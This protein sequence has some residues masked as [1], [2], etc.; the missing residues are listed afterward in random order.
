MTTVTTI[1][2]VIERLDALVRRSERDGSRLGYFAALY[3]AVT[4]EVRTAIGEGRFEDGDRMSRFDAAFGARYFTAVDALDRGDRPS[5]CWAVAFA[6]VADP[7]LIIAQ[8]LLLGVNAHINLDLA[9]AAAEVAPGGDIVDLHRDFFT[10]N[11]I[12]IHV[13]DRI[14]GAL[15]DVSPAMKLLDFAGWWADEALLSFSV[16]K[17][18]SEA[19]SEALRL[20]PQSATER[21]VSMAT[22][23][24]KA[25]HLALRLTRPGPPASWLVPQV[26]E[27]EETDIAA[28]IAHLDGVAA[29]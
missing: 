25:T 5:S 11:G 29:P 27:Q 14:Q 17:A 21:A 6:G 8:H 22:L 28:V 13:L 19:W 7:D 20:A 1:D 10:I 9:I 3:R 18:R 2:A 15:G 12:L 16:R 4:V 24:A 23:D 26:R